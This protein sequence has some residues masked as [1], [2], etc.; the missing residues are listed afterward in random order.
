MNISINIHYGNYHHVGTSWKNRIFYGTCWRLVYASTAGARIKTRHET[1]EFLPDQVY[2]LPPGLPFTGH[3]ENDPKLL[4]LHFDAAHPYDRVQTQVYSTPLDFRLNGLLK[5]TLKEVEAPAFLTNKGSMLALAFV[6]SALSTIPDECIEIEPMDPRIDEA[7]R[8]IKGKLMNPIT[9]EDVAQ[10]IGMSRSSF[11]RLFKK[12]TGSTP[13]Q[14]LTEVR[15][16]WACTLLAQNTVPID[17]IAAQT[18]FTD[19][20]HFSKVFKQWIGIP[21]AA[22]RRQES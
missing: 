21:P 5:D 20:F 11:I 1:V 7:I 22:Y 17:D 19:R 9:I 10:Q 16:S 8:F 4:Y 3:Q 12:E 2:L 13:H 14:Y 6:A 15:I 18:G